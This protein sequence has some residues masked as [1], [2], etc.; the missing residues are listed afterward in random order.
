[1]WNGSSDTIVEANSFFDNGRDIAFGLGPGK[2]SAS[3]VSNASL[4]DHRGGRIA[5]NSVTRRSGLPGADIAI[6]VADSPDT[7]IEQNIVTMSRTYP[8]A[9]EYRFPRTTGV[10]I[11]GNSVDGRIEGRDGASAS[12]SGNTIR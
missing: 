12:V 2:T 10:L 5:G 6:S 4:P 9:I 3:P 11:T 1:M 8:N 7:R